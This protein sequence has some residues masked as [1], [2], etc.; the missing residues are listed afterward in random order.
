MKDLLKLVIPEKIEIIVFLMAAL[1]L[2]IVENVKRFWV[3]ADG[4]SLSSLQAAGGYDTQ[5]SDWF[6]NL[7]ARIDPHFADFIV[8]VLIGSVLFVGLSYVVAAIK[9]VRNEAELVSYYKSPQGRVHEI[10]VFLT[11]LA[12]RV[13]G[14][15]GLI[16]WSSIFLKHINPAISKL[17]FSSIITI[18]DP[19]SWLWVGLSV[20]ALTVALYV[21]A[22]FARLIALKTRVF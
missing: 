12:I 10:N 1:G 7:Q 18:R 2:L 17:F 6:I 5:I 16:V 13:I 14:V 20:I 9:S 8:W 4:Q 15:F 19:A 22:I 21:F 11:K 3:F